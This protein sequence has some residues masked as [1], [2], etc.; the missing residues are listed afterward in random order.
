[1]N[2]CKKR[3]I[4]RNQRKL[5]KLVR[6]EPYKGFI[7]VFRE[8]IDNDGSLTE[9]YKITN[10]ISY[11]HLCEDWLQMQLLIYLSNPIIVIWL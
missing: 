6:R 1:M 3:L 7:N 2:T 10:F 11:E 8:F 4:N 5:K 9:N